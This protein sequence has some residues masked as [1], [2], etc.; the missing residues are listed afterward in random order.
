M[1]CEAPFWQYPSVLFE[2][3]ALTYEAKCPHSAWNFLARIVILSL[4][5]GMVGSALGGLMVIPIAALFGFLT[6]FALIMA[7]RSPHWGEYKELPMS[8]VVDPSGK[9]VDPSGKL[10]DPSGKLVDPPR[11]DPHA[12]I[13]PLKEHFV[14]GGSPAPI[15]DPVGQEA[16]DAA[17]YSGPALPEHTPP[18]SRNPFMNILLDEIKYQPHRP[19]AAPVTHSAVEQVM[20]DYFRIQWHSDPTDVYGKKQGQRQFIT[21]PITTM[22]NDQGGFADWLYKIPGKTCKEGGRPACLAMTENGHI[23]WM[24]QA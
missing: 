6:A 17:P 15:E 11:V 10:V 18:T 21:Q 20:D 4:F 19:P 24:S 7:P 3:F 2:H 14:N 1:A 16:I 12:Y 23:P 22:P 13:A 9:L 5:V 8:Q